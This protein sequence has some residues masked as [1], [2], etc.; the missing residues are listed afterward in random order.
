M[1]KQQAPPDDIERK[2]KIAANASEA[3]RRLRTNQTYEDWRQVGALMLIITEE[4]LDDLGL[5]A[6][7]QDNKKLT[8]EFTKRF[9]GWQRIVSNAAPITKQ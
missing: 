3:L 7:D 1:S 2:A 9:E 5:D 8:R 4:T 6:W